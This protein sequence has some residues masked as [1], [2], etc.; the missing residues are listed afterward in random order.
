MPVGHTSNLR[1]HTLVG[2]VLESR[3][4]LQDGD[5]AGRNDDLDGDDMQDETEVNGDSTADISV[6]FPSNST[7]LTSPRRDEASTPT[8][9][10]LQSLNPDN[11]VRFVEKVEMDE[12]ASVQPVET[13][14]MSDKVFSQDEPAG[15]E[16]LRAVS[17]C[18]VGTVEQ[19]ATHRTVNTANS[20]TGIIVDRALRSGPTAKWREVLL[21]FG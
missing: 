9:T 4:L 2:E 18:N 3:I 14:T 16:A 6:Q 7:P 1:V 19:E 13:A 20:A 11:S 21:V 5:C 12:R 8:N 17:V 15:T 10:E